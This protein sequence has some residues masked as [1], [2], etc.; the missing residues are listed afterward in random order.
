MHSTAARQTLIFD[1]DDTLWGSNAYFEAVIA[2]FLDWLAHPELSHAEIRAVLDD[3]ERA[4]A[5]TNGYGSQAFLLNL[6][7]C[8][9]TLNSRPLDAAEQR[10]I[11]ELAV[12]LIE[13]RVQLFD[14][15]ADTLEVLAGRHDLKLMTKGHPDEQTRKIAASG[16]GTMFSSIHIVPEKNPD[17]YAGIVAAQGLS[18]SSSWMIGNSP[19]S[20]ILPARAVGLGAVYIPSSDTWV[21]EQAELDPDDHGVLTL[22]SFPDLLRHF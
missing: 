4:N 12:D 5:V 15:V 22:G 1:A 13:H 7:E 21:L 14:G 11:N 20:D 17:V 8:F 16:L 3:I 19:R 9:R 2:D 10:Q 6:A 18:P